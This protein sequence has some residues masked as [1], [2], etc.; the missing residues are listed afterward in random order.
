MNKKDMVTR[1]IFQNEVY[2]RLKDVAELRGVSVARLKRAIEKLNIPTTVIEG[3]G[4]MKW[5]EERYVN[6]IELDNEIVYMRTEFKDY[7]RELSLKGTAS[8]IACM[9][10]D[11]EVDTSK[12][13]YD[14]MKDMDK[15]AEETN[16]KRKNEERKKVEIMNTIFEETNVA[17]RFVS[18]EFLV[19]NEINQMTVLVDG[20]GKIVND[21]HFADYIFDD[22]TINELKLEIVE[23]GGIYEECGDLFRLNFGEPFECDNMSVH[24]TNE[25]LR[26]MS[27]NQI[28]MFSND[29]FDV[30]LDNGKY[31]GVKLDTF[32]DML[33]EDIRVVA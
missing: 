12:I 27:K 16:V 8:A 20:E 3:F 1:L 18:F 21:R 23:C 31:I 24:L 11:K 2:Y 10:F 19:G 29:W 6:D 32:L 9:L 15:F 22:E 5:I 13:V 14:T 26:N 33:N 4:R 28:D 7:Q 25:L 30:E 17:E